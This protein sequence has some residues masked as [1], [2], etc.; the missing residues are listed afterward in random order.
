MKDL[1]RILTC[2]L[3]LAG[4]GLGAVGCEDQPPERFELLEYQFALRA[5][6]L[7]EGSSASEGTFQV[8]STHQI[9]VLI[10]TG[11]ER[12]TSVV[13]RVWVDVKWNQSRV[14]KWDRGTSIVLEGFGFGHRNYLRSEGFGW[15]SSWSSDGS[16][17]VS[18]EW[19]SFKTPIDI[20][21]HIPQQDGPILFHRIRWLRDPN[22]YPDVDMSQK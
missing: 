17:M 9:P 22:L 3:G 21:T 1:L 15:K 11:P 6:P 10:G 4:V 5:E 13:D 20:S 8:I 2:I 18:D 14:W 19:E 16:L 12:H 7:S